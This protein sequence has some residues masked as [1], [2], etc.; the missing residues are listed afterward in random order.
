MTRP[1]NTLSQR[2]RQARQAGLTLVELMVALLL[3][4]ILSA[5][6]FYLM[7]GQHKTYTGQLHQMTINENLWGAMEYLQ[8]E[9]RKAGYG[10][11]GCPSDP[12]NGIH[13][14]VV[15][16]W[17][18]S[19]ACSAPPPC[20]KPDTRLQA[21]RIFNSYN[22]YTKKAFASGQG[23]DSFAV[24]Y[25]EDSGSNVLTAL[26]TTEKSPPKTGA[27]VWTNAGGDSTKSTYIKKGDLLVVWQHGSTKPCTALVATADGMTAGTKHK[28]QFNPGHGYNPPPGKYTSIFPTLGYNARSLVL[29][30]GNVDSFRTR[31]FSLDSDP[32]VKGANNTIHVPRLMTWLEDA[33]G[34]RFDEQVIA[35]GIEDMQLSWACDVDNLG[36]LNEGKNP[37]ARVGD[38]WANN[39]ANDTAPV[40][41]KSGFSNP[42]QA[43]RLSLVGRPIDISSSKVLYRPACEDRPAGTAAEDLNL[44]GGLGTFQRSMLIS[45][46]K[47]RNIRKSVL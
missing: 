4:I 21:M 19:T 11:A 2:Q 37:P 17:N 31:F 8:S 36:T 44:T 18:E 3:A 22:A 5:G 15:Q 1:P 46:V 45:T 25:A 39:V 43:V 24:S 12:T 40:C 28:L 16:K 32:T 42:I 6:L 33:N 10:F 26:R 29:R 27:V 34:K 9:I 30:I 38:E 23:P 7:S 47:P 14:P 13:V 20:I 41:A 35:E